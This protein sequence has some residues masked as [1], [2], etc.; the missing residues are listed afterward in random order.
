M[1]QEIRE[2][3]ETYVSERRSILDQIE[4]V[5]GHQTRRPTA[6]EVETWIT[7]GR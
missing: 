2:L 6:E 7:A 5:W 3:L 4:E 1:E